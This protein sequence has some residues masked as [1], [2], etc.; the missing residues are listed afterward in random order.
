MKKMVGMERTRAKVAKE[1]SVKR[2]GL[3]KS[4]ETWNRVAEEKKMG[5]GNLRGY[6]CN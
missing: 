4:L 2:K 6:E 5:H 3:D 1:K